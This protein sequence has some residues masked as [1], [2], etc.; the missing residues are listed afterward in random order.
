MPLGE[1]QKKVKQPF[2]AT[3][4]TLNFNK[5]E[6]S[7]SKLFNL[8]AT[9]ASAESKITTSNHE[10]SN[11]KEVKPLDI[12]PNVKGTLKNVDEEKGILLF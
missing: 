8:S 4:K 2:T 1:S 3:K 5:S 9:P 10:D 7:D 6:S 11:S 12:S